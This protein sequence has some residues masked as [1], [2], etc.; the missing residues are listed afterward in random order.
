MDQENDNL[1]WCLESEQNP[2]STRDFLP[3][4]AVSLTQ[5]LSFKQVYRVLYV[6]RLKRAHIYPF[7]YERQLLSHKVKLLP[8]YILG[9]FGMK[10]FWKCIVIIVVQHCQ[11]T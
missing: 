6:S 3:V 10:K 4:I 9:L 5:N 11:G 8:K 2:L 7:K 1:K